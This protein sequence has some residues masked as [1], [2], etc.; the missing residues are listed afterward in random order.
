MKPDQIKAE[1]KKK[2]SLKFPNFPLCVFA[3][4]EDPEYQELPA[5][6]RLAWAFAETEI[7]ERRST[8]V[9][10]YLLI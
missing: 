10:P 5:V 3:V 1:K 4:S 8:I 2:N 7:Q 6:S 9:S